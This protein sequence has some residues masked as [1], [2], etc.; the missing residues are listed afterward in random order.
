MRGPA[1][2]IRPRTFPVHRE[3]DAVQEIA[4]SEFKFT[5]CR[6]PHNH[7]RIGVGADQAMYIPLRKDGD[8]FS[9]NDQPPIWSFAGLA[10]VYVECYPSRIKMRIVL[11]RKAETTAKAITLP[12]GCVDFRDWPRQPA[13]PSPQSTRRDAV[14]YFKHSRQTGK[15]ASEVLAGRI[16]RSLASPT[17]HLEGCLLQEKALEL[18]RICQ[19]TR[20]R[21]PVRGRS[22]PGARPGTMRASRD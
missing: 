20:L 19:V 8:V 3:V 2:S 18:G 11:H 15:S 1:G 6:A 12:Q 13:I 7:L 17:L 9:R 4:M 14:S 10:D 21:R 16:R 5:I 22:G